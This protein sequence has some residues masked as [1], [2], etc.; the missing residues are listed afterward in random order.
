M[1]NNLGGPKPCGICTGLTPASTERE[2]SSVHGLASPAVTVGSTVSDE[3]EIV[4]LAMH[5]GAITARIG[6]DDNLIEHVIER[7]D[8]VDRLYGMVS[9]RF[10]RLLVS[11]RETE[12]LDVDQSAI[13][14]HQTTARRSPEIV[15]QATSTVIRD[16]DI[17]TAYDVLDERDNL[18]AD[19]ETLERE[20][21]ERNVPESHLIAFTIDSVTRTAECGGNTAETA[22]QA[23]ARNQQL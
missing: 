21:H 20:P 3:D 1:F 19:L 14:D 16:S 18:T 11:L 23:A 8:Q 17:D 5:E 10:Q 9:R 4:A 13:Y 12:E 2:Y 7:D 22:L 15:E 6:R